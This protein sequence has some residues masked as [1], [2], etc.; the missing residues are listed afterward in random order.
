[1]SKEFN[2][3][4]G[5]DITTHIDATGKP[6]N[7]N[8]VI[9]DVR[10]PD[11]YAKEHIEG[12]INIPLAKLQSF[13]F[14][15]YQNATL[16]FHCKLGSRTKQAAHILANI[17]CKQA[18]CLDGGIEQWKQ[19]GLPTQVNLKAPLELMRQV[20]IIVGLIILIGLGLAYVISSYFLLLPLFAGIGLLIAG[21]TGFCGMAKLLMMLP[22]N[23][24]R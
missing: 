15:P 22:Y 24:S 21:F 23:K 3:L 7:E 13:D 18:Y 6:K 16:I 11:E 14:S 12:S 17:P 4:Q 1:M 9:I 10:E 5:Q 19:M 2:F 20:Q 8:T